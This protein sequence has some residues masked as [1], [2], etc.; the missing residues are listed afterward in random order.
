MLLLLVFLASILPVPMHYYSKDK[1]LKF[2]TEQ[3]DKKEEEE[4]EEEILPIS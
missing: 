4:E 1:N 3:V 2:L